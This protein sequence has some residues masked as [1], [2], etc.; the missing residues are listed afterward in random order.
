MSAQLIEMPLCV[1]NVA[2][3][4]VPHLVN[5][6]SGVDGILLFFIFLNDRVC[7]S[8]FR[9]TCSTENTTLPTFRNVYLLVFRLVYA[10]QRQS[11][12]HA[13]LHE[14]LE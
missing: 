12:L 8:A 11:R 1:H 10:E 6:G 9:N 14:P 2:L 7:T 13:L 4:Q 3:I 5:I